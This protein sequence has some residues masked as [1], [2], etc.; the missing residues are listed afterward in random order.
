MALACALTSCTGDQALPP[1]NKP[2]E[3]GD[4]VL[5]NGLWNSPMSAYQVSLGSIPTDEFGLNRIENWVTGYIVGW[6]N[7]DVSNTNIELGADFTVPAQAA[8]NL[9][10]A[11][12]PDEK[13]PLNVASVQ[14]PSGAVRNALNL[15]DHPENL[16]Q[17]VTIYGEVGR[18]YCG[19]YGVRSVSDYNWGDQGKEPDPNM[20]LPS[21]AREFWT[22]DL[23]KDM[24]GFTF[25]QGSPS[26]AGFETWKHST[27]YG[28][29][30]TGG[31]SGSAV[32]TEAM[33]ISPVIDLTD[34]TQPRMMIH[35][36]GNYFNG[37]AGFLNMCSV[38]V[39]LS[40]TTDWKPVVMPYA[41]SGSSWTFSNSGY[42]VLDDFAGQKIEI[43]F[44]YTSTAD[45]SGTWEIDKVTIAGV[46]K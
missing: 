18:K 21:G 37:Q 9:L 2:A 45:F 16:Y 19:A 39:R 40:G 31:R 11:S 13:N 23:L 41:P 6:V 44:R 22:A 38:L 35:Q 3:M 20:V 34:Y 30:A 10:I 24:Q 12:R 36:A 8:T 5:G 28:L 25:D 17:Q 33:A 42:V 32:T 29:V 14:L 4:A 1:V 27:S 26:Q 46:H 43:G 15:Q 7:V